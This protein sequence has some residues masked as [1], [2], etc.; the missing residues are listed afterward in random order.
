MR[1]RF[2]RGPTSV[3]IRTVLCEYVINSQAYVN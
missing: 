2:F 1:R 3:R